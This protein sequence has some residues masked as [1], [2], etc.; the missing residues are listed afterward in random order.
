MTAISRL[1]LTLAIAIAAA[2]PSPLRV[3]PRGAITSP[4][5]KGEP[6]VMPRSEVRPLRSDAGSDYLIYI[7]WPQQ[8][9]PPEGYPILYLLDGSESF[10]IAAEYQNRLGSYAGMAP[11]IVVGI[12]YPDVSRRN[13]DY[14]PAVPEGVQLVPGMGP[15]GGAEPF[16]DF[17][18]N[19]VI[20]LVEAGHSVDANRRTLAGYSLG[21]LLTLQALFKRPDLFQTY[22]A[23]SPSIWFGE[24][25][26]LKMLPGFAERLDGLPSRRRML[27]SAGEYE[28]SPPPGM[29]RDPSWRRIAD[30]SRHAR[31]V[32]N[33]RELADDLQSA[34]MHVEFRVEPGET[35]ATGNWPAL[36][37]AL[38]LAFR[39]EP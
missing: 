2:H 14:T 37:D 33:A 24:K 27:L 23:S 26:I 13:F 20:P 36:R 3:D 9:P 5:S 15:T 34:P 7:A 10:A 1:A 22:V 28:Q 30:I 35:H 38:R 39:R 29:E 16:L 31:M 19:K 32:D 8:P 25:Q 4:N 11:G 6:Y 21:G 12:G 17:L 18:A